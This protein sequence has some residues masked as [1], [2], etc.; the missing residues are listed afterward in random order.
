MIARRPGASCRLVALTLLP[1]LSACPP[2][3]TMGTARAIPPGAFQSWV[4]V[5][6]YHTTLVTGE[7]PDT[8]TRDEMW[9]PLLEV[10]ARFGIAA[11]VDLGARA[12]TG[13][14]SIFPRFQLVRAESEEAGVD[15]LLEPSVGWTS[16]APETRVSGL[17]V[18]LALPFGVNLGGG[19]QV[20]LT[21]RAA[22]VGDAVLGTTGLAGGS[23]ALALR[24]GGGAGG[25][26]YLIPEC[27]VVGVGD[28]SAS[29][30][31]PLVQCALGLAGPWR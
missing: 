17:F 29:F 3:T 10:G 12:G 23:L 24:V 18:G 27:A 25:G 21:P 20:V 16:L 26:W 5:G 11:G 7:P 1:L 6:A 28:G 4:S 31:G 19:S 9:L 30:A 13:G 8:V 2:L 14:G 22:V 15:L